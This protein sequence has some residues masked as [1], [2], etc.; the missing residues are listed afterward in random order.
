MVHRNTDY[1]TRLLN[2]LSRGW[3]TSS[4]A[5]WAVAFMPVTL[6]TKKDKESGATSRSFKVASEDDAKWLASKARYDADPREVR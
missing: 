3:R 5:K 2:G 4:L 1:I 6:V